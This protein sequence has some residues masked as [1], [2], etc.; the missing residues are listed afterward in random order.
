MTCMKTGCHIWIENYG[1]WG[2]GDAHHIR[3][4]WVFRLVATSFEPMN[5]RCHYTVTEIE[6]WF[7]RERMEI[8]GRAISTLFAAKVKDHGYE[9]R[10]IKGQ[11]E[12]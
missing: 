11:A 5:A 1:E 9:G 4:L 12:P 3:G 7:D 8:T 2:Y 10:E 6:D